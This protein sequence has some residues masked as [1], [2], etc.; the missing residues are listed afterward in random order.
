MGF[1]SG[2]GMERSYYVATANPFAPAAKLEGELNA[3]VVIIGGGYT[4]LS[5]ALRLARDFSVVVLEAGRVGWG[6]SGRNGGQLIPGW[7]KGA[8]DLVKLYGA[9]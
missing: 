7:R 9:E 3:D 2:L 4:G 5:T 6:A 8:A 1:N